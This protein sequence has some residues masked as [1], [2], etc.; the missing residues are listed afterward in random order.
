MHTEKLRLFRAIRPVDPRNVVRGQYAGYRR[1]PGVAP[2]SR[3]ETFVALR[4]H[5]DTW[6]WSGV[7]FYIRAGKRMPIN[8]TEVTVDLKR[9]PLAVFDE[10]TSAGSNYFR[11]RLSPEVVI[12]AGARVKRPG[13]EMRGEPVE[14][15]ARH[16]PVGE[17]SPYERL[18]RDAILNDTTLYTSDQTVEAAWRVVEPI[19]GDAAPLSSYE[20]ETWGPSGA[21]SVVAGSEGW[22]DPVA[23]VRPC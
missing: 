8:A 23:E 19:L 16:S 21:A 18:I 13:G 1:E 17:R 20:P 5:V 15:L 11:F 10:I 22:H 14:L 7:P 12:S 4:L 3:V 9:P 6:R 2:D